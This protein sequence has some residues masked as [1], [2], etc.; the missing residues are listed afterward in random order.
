MFDSIRSHRRWVMPILVIAVF[1][2][3]VFS[4]IYGF[5]RF[6]GDENTVAKIDGE[7]I[8]Q[9][10]LEVAQRERVERMIQMLGPNIDP[11]TLDTPQARASTLDALLSEKA[12]DHEAARLRIAISDARLKE[13]IGSVPQFQQNGKFDYDT[14][15]RLLQMRGFS[16]ASF[17]ARVRADISRQTMD[18][19]VTAG[20][21]LPRAVVDHLLALEDERRQVRRLVFRPEEFL[22]KVKIG[23]D[24]I[25]SEYESNKDL[26]RTPERVK[27][28]YLVLRLE[29]LAAR[30]PVSEAAMREYYEK[31]KS[32]WAGTEQRRASHI[33]ITSGKDGSAPDKAAA[34]QMAEEILRQVRAKPADFA[35]LAREKSKDP[36]SAA[37]GGDLGWFGR[38]MMTK[39]F[40]DAAFALQQ[41][42]ISDVVETEFGF[43]IIMVTGVK[44]AQP[45][46]FEEVRSTI[47]AEMR[48]QAAQK[49]YAEMAEQFTNFVYE[50]SDGLK[51]AAEKFQLPLKTIDNLTRQGAPPQS[52]KSTVAIFTPAVLDAVFS[53]D[54]LQRHHNT[55]AID[56]GNNSLV[57]VHVDDYT[58]PDVR[59]LETVRPAIKAKLER[60]AAIRL[61]RQ[62]GEARL[63]Q[64]GQ[65]P[66]DKGFEAMRELGRRDT[67]YLPGPAINTLMTVPAGRLPAYVGLEQPDGSYAVFH[68]LAVAKPNTGGDAARAGLTKALTER[69]AS[70]EESEY[71]QALRERFDA[72]VTRSDLRAPGKGGEPAPKP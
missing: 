38:S 45:K 19:G 33:L 5:T 57:S 30:T 48:K 24:A 52:D 42:Q 58:P 69:V 12:I 18:A 43:H 29:D 27:A 13:L 46:S 21:L 41:G 53:P 2:P 4:G 26:Y 65:T 40:E 7:N 16:E 3:F 62:A 63:G 9:Q 10:E 60:S 64:L 54:A 14:Y 37:M 17:E 8:T 66:D 35:K 51:A 31:N 15:L 49:N 36:G 20:A 44:S 70:A 55:K 72:R 11:R 71:V 68:V 56:I 23:E 25:K 59:P 39:P 6:L 22:A 1:L 32:R 61:A 50:Q 34:R 28:E 47:E 67:D